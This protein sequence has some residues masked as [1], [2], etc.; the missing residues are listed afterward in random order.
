MKLENAF[1]CLR[2]LDQFA[3]LYARKVGV[4]ARVLGKTLW[5]DYYLDAK[6]KTVKKGA[7]VK[8]LCDDERKKITSPADSCMFPL[9][10]LIL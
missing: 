1:N 10:L 2:R 7:Q 3:E 6:T 5:G 4:S 8:C 9:M